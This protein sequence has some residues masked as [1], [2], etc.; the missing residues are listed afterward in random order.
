MLD[1]V[2]R[3]LARLA[4]IKGRRPGRALAE[5]L[6]FENGFQAVVLHRVAHALRR[7]G[8]PFFGPF[9]ARLGL[10]LTGVDI[11][12]AAVIG[13]GLY[14]SH[15]VGLVIGGGVVIGERAFLLGGVNLGAPS[16][17]RLDEMPTLGD[18]V[19]VGAGATAPRPDRDRRPGVRRRQRRGHPGRALGQQGPLRG[20]D[21]GHHPLP[22]GGRA[23]SRPGPR[24][25]VRHADRSGFWLYAAHL[26]AVPRIALSNVLHQTPSHRRGA[27]TR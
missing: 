22:A 17:A 23:L 7:R 14:V 10:L 20:R 13:P 11:S 24:S 1:T 21:R 16:Q 4:E 3:D 25:M 12:P 18:D 2:R 19:F 26:F 15:G 6:L 27:G 5:G 9:F 8:I